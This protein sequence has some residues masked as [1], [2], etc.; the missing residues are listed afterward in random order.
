MQAGALARVTTWSC[1]R[2]AA[3]VTCKIIGVIRWIL[4][5][6]A[7]D[8][9]DELASLRARGAHVVEVPCLE[10]VFHPWPWADG[11]GLTLFTSRR[12]VAA[13]AASRAAV[14]SRCV[15]IAP[16]TA[17]AARAAGLTPELEVD[18]GVVALARA[19][20]E[21]APDLSVVR[22]PGSNHD[23]QEQQDALTLLSA[24]ATVDRRVVYETRAPPQLPRQ[25]AEAVQDGWSAH[26]ASPSAVRHFFDAVP[27]TRA[28]REV[29]CHGASTAREWNARRPAGWPPAHPELS[30]PEVT[31]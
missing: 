15:A 17:H 25:L 30:S 1:G 6:E 4:T 21:R 18:G 31:P 16:A 26:F 12:S 27:A 22:Y 10:T 13:W 20:L 2:C 9:G 24:R 3:F 7:G 14:P 11:A 19:V 29:L 23:S 8:S 28:P 5:R